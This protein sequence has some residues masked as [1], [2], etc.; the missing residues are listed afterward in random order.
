MSALRAELEN[1]HADAVILDG[2]CGMAVAI[3]CETPER[4]LSSLL[5]AMEQIASRISNGLDDE[6][7]P[8]GGE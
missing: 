2:L 3:C 8:K 6:N 1:L 4:D 5:M 7:L